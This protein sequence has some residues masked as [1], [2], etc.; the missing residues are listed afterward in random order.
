MFQTPDIMSMAT[1][2]SSNASARL[3]AIARNVANA[4]TPGYR[5]VDAAPFRGAET[6]SVPFPAARSRPGHLPFS[7]HPATTALVERP[8][9]EAAPNGNNVSIESEMMQ[10]ALVRHDN[11]V[12]LGIYKSALDILR[13]S[14]GRR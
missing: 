13:A 2:M 10:A 14:L 6:Q 4:D 1:R 8:G 12:A 5:A 7:A 3:A 9:G 11:E